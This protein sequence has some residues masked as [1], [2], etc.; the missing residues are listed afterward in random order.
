M[1]PM[2]RRGFLKV[3]SRTVVSM[4]AASAVLGRSAS[5]WASPNDVIRVA[6]VGFNGRGTE[7]I[8]AFTG[9][10]GKG[11]EIAALVD[12]DENI[13]GG[14]PAKSVEAA[15]G[16]PPALYSDLRKMLED[17]SIDA[18]SIA[19]P[20][21]WH[22]LAA[23]WAVQAG[24]DVYVEKPISHNV[25]EGRQLV[26]AARNNKRI[27]QHGTQSRSSGSVQEAV[28]F[29]RSGKLGK[30]YMAKG[31]CFK[32]RGSIGKVKG[33]TPVPKGVDYDL[34]TGPAPMKPIHR[35]RLHYDWHWQWD[36]GDGDI[37]NQGVHEMDIARWGLGRTLPNTV[38]SSGGRYGYEDD[39]ETPNTQLA[40]FDYGDCELVFEV[41]G[42]PTNDEKEVMVG[43]IF[44]GSEGYM[45][46]NRGKWETYF[47]HKNEPGPKGPSGKG[48]TDHFAN[49]IAAV[50]S[51]KPSDLN[52]PAEEGHFSAALCHLGNISY[53]LGRK[54]RFDPKAENFINDKEA[55]ELLTR[56]YR[57][58]FIVPEIV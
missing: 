42:L 30:I 27:V 17:K 11:T 32:P 3:S 40:I 31:H 58:P 36:Y 2:D 16:K 5:A 51:R 19:T 12:V 37:G 35:Q 26:K 55:D 46:V 9:G 20:N 41:R 45:V 39:G 34:W 54:L 47:G 56:D 1:E 38:F 29:L 24:K 6:V 14:K 43:N 48:G 13:W 8:R 21:H 49:F 25:W 22:S 52:A 23:I 15:Q 28:E 57:S 33:D 53:R 18:V 7:H 50:K 10:K 44:Y 4:A